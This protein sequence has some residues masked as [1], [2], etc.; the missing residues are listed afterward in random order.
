MSDP[1]GPETP[2]GP[3]VPVDTVHAF[4]APPSVLVPGTPSGPLAGIALGVKALIDV[5]GVVTTAGS[6][7][8]ARGR[9]PASASAPCVSALVAAGATV[10]GVTV[11]DELAYSLAGRNVHV[12]QPVNVAA[13]GRTPGGSS[14]GSAAAVAAGLVPLALA[15]DT[16]GSI[17]V[18]ASYCGIFGWRPTHGAVSVEGVV[19]LS[20]SF[21]TVGLLA[22]SAAL[23]AAGAEVLVRHAP[24]TN[25]LE[26]D[27]A[28]PEVRPALVDDVLAATAPEVRG[29]V[30]A[31]TRRA[32]GPDLGSISLGVDLLVAREAFRVLQSL[33]AWATHGAWIEAAHPTLGPDIA[34]RFEAASAI[35]SDEVEWARPVQ[36]QVRAAIVAA[37][38]DGQAL[39]VPA[40][41]GVAPPIGQGGADGAATRA[42]T[43]SLTC[44]AGLAGAPVVVVPGAVV[45]DLPVGVAV[46]GAPGSDL[47][48]L[49]WAASLPVPRRGS[50]R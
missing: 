14:V 42:A 2:V 26:A 5:A 33:E 29:A 38:A 3:V 9:A 30:A 12:A 25:P 39:V 49:G 44:L 7:D 10:V 8:F 20:P 17:R 50:T 31:A 24:G 16:G 6:P 45:D 11:S 46:I 47:A 35:P 48:L 32:V 28:R 36:E 19:P 23:L 13:P 18:P 27:G 34:E 40:A 43:M 41:A 4:A 21:D 15:T 37:T 1:S 22:A